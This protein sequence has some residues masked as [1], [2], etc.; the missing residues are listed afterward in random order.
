MDAERC[1]HGAG[2]T[3][4]RATGRPADRYPC[5]LEVDLDAVRQNARAL[6]RFVGPRV[7]LAA[8]VK[9]DGYGLG[10]EPIARAA[11]DGGAEALAVA[12]V[13]EG[14]ALR[15]A[16]VGAPILL[17]TCPAPAEAEQVVRWRLTATVAEPDL[18]E[19]LARAAQRLGV[20]APVHL[21]LDTGLTRYGA[22]PA[23]AE[24]LA[25]RL[26]SLAG[27]R[28]EGLYTHFAC[29]DN[30]DEEFTRE[31]LARLL[32]FRDRLARDGITFGCTHA[33]NSA[34]ALLD[35][36]THLDLVRAGIAL[37][38]TL[39]GP[40]A[41]VPLRPALAFKTRI[42]RFHHLP[43]GAT[44]GY[45]R[46]YVVRRPTRAALLLAGYADGVPRALSNRGEV[47]VRGRRAPLI[48]RVSMDQ[49]LADVTDIPEAQVGDEV[50][51]F[52]RQG[53]AEITLV[54]FAAWADTIPHEALCRLGPRV[55][56]VYLSEL[57]LATDHPPNGPARG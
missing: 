51:F 11:L 32:A 18:P 19:R 8:V 49:C 45:D 13:D 44:V 36:A 43:V 1:D 16:G 4:G 22:P 57:A 41:S 40:R 21:K 52:G 35:P 3:L 9:A 56:R 6:K 12:R 50:V 23:E 20:E 33:A 2:A 26:R 28:A 48:G 7:R 31:Q 24:L 14:L 29:S 37:T 53:D 38:G 46:T 34:A 42:A 25:V 10:A 30:G 54:E 55:P 5:W 17:L 47:L 15:R 39:G 27:L